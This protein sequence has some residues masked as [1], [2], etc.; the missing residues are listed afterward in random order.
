[1][2]LK[3]TISIVL[4]LASVGLQAQNRVLSGKVVDS[5]GEELIGASIY[6]ENDQKRPLTGVTA[7]V[8]GNYAFTVPPGE[9]LTIVCSFV[10]Y[11]SQRVKYLN[12]TELNFELT[13]ESTT[14]GGVQI[15]GEKVDRNSLG[16]SNFEQVSA[17]QKFDLEQVKE[18]PISSIEQGLQGRLANVDIL[19]GGDP[20]SRSSIRI[21]GTATLNANAEPL[22]VIDGVP[23]PT[24]IQDD[25]NFATANDEDF[26]ALVNISPNDI[27]SIEV[28]KDAAATAIWGSRGANGVLVFTTK[29][30]VPGKTRFSFSSKFD[31]K[32]EARTISHAGRIAICESCAG[33]H[34]E[35]Y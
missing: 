20:G 24:N 30:G 31:I 23:Y 4:M 27:A 3:F 21:R 9:N 33:C 25:F 8:S 13:E 16:I 34:L 6:I 35:F 5:K 15:L 11:E 18:M 26:G 28:L 10:G 29:K 22:I 12:Q 17:T 2:K 1:M 19:S 32:K 7:D 14:L